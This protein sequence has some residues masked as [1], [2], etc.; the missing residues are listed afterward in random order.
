[1]RNYENLL[2]E[3]KEKDE[4]KYI[5]ATER[6][7]EL[8][9][10]LLE[11]PEYLNPSIPADASLLIRFSKNRR[12]DSWEL[13]VTGHR[14]NDTYLR[15]SRLFKSK[16]ECVSVIKEFFEIQT[17]IEA[18]QRS[19]ENVSNAQTLY[20]FRVLDRRNQVIAESWT[21]AS[22]RSVTNP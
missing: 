13:V 9:T 19:A 1:M 4:Q 11:L 10:R 7:R 15:S 12:K 2:E 17:S 14:P 20:S 8:E 5:V 22:E 16:E 21:F 3:V 18:V 6:I